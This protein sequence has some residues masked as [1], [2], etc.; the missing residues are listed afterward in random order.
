MDLI[1]LDNIENNTIYD[2]DNFEK[3]NLKAFD[4]K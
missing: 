1:L 2:Y 3:K 4:F